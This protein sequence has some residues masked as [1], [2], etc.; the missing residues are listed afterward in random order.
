MQLEK[1]RAGQDNGMKLNLRLRVS[2]SVS[3][4]PLPVECVRLLIGP[5]GGLSIEEIAAIVQYQLTDILLG[6]CVLRTGTTA[7]TVTTALRACFGDLG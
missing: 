6:P 5:E 4:L 2:A 1:W 7:L 3:T